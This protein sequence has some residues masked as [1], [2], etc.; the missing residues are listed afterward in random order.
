[1]GGQIDFKLLKPKILKNKRKFTNVIFD[2][3]LTLVDSTCLEELRKERK[4]S[5]VY[6]NIDKCS[7]YDGL[8]E[9]F[10][11]IRKIGVSVAIVSTAPRPYL[12][13]MVRHFNIPCDH[14]VGYHDAKPIKPDPATMVKA[15]QLLKARA[16]DTVSFGDRSID[17]ISSKRA[18]IHAVGCLWGTKEEAHLL[19]VGCNAIINNPQE[20]L[21]YF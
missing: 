8:E 12:E 14:I 17:I 13:R 15:L 18:G 16:E 11:H 6:A 21:N 5:E 19:E 10:E 4:W 1:M 3:D 9:V 7:L 2:L 20:M